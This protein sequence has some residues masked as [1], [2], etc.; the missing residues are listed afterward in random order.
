VVDESGLTGKF[1]M[2]LQWNGPVRDR[3][4]LPTVSLKNALRDQGFE[5]RRAKRPIDALV[6]ES[7]EKPDEDR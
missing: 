5:L 1:D 6:I 3:D 4:G 7:A 2:R